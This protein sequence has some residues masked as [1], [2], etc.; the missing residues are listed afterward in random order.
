MSTANPIRSSFDVV[1][2]GAGPAG[3]AAAV[4]A[5]GSR[6]RTALVDDNPAAGGQ[7][8]R[9]ADHAPDDSSNR[10]S[11]PTASAVTWFERLRSS[12]VHHLYGARVFRADHGVV[13]AETA[14]AIFH[15]AYRDLILATG[16]RELF[17]PF[18]GWTLPNVL[19]AG[20]LQAL[21]KSG[22]PVRNKRIVIAGTGPLLLA[23]AA[24][25]QDHGAS[26]IA[27]C[28][29]A[30]RGALARFAWHAVRTPGKIREAWQLLR[31][32]GRAALYTNSW[33]IAALGAHGRLQALR[34]S[35]NGRIRE[36]ECDYVGCGFHLV[37]NVE[38]PRS[39]GCQLENGFVRVDGF[40]QTSVPHVYCAG[41][42][43]GIGGLELSVVEGEIAGY[44]AGG[45]PAAIAPL[46]PQCA[47]HRR[48]ARALSQAFSLRPELKKLA[49]PDTW[50]CRCED[51]SL[52]RL[53][54]HD[55]WRAAKL[56]TRCGMGPCQ[57]RVCGAALDFL[58]GWDAGASRAPIFPVSCA[59]L[60]ALPS[61]HN[62][63]TSN[64]GA[65]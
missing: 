3:I 58:F 37:P 20:G 22:L 62:P 30:S 29:Q 35:H 10:A 18:P 57:G 44:A 34:I 25:L 45:R 19:G 60:A 63:N 7:I 11:D 47:Q 50:I 9:V 53:R 40:Q 39:L 24:Y 33:P 43:T 51:V 5:A 2:V 61:V 32:I 4:S 1:V 17:L 16:A 56:H 36:I 52:D 42:P 27:I 31:R 48:F 38:L 6:A 23:V 46:F 49:Q 64:G 54:E 13:N 55:S 26:V 28:E 65:Q 12:S 15:I 21:A 59:S 41:E 8:W 14:D